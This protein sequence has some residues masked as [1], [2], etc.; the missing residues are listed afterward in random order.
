MSHYV[1]DLEEL[2]AERMPQGDKI[3]QIIAESQELAY[4][5]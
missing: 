1:L 5:A 4:A 2:K 3:S